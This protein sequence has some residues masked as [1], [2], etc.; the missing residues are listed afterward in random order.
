MSA[1]KSTPAKPMS[2]DGRQIQ[3]IAACLAQ[4]SAILGLV[5][6]HALYEDEAAGDAVG[7]AIGLIEQAAALAEAMAN[8]EST[9]KGGAA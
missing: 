4:A 8:A 1:R 3:R 6:P 7:G 2:D 5:R 9:T